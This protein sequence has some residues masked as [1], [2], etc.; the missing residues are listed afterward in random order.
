VHSSLKTFSTSLLSSVPRLV[1]RTEI[2]G[3]SCTTY[4][5][6]GPLEAFVDV[7][8]RESLSAILAVLSK[9]GLP[10]RVLGAGSNVLISSRGLSGLTL[11]LGRGFRYQIKDG[12]KKLRVGASTSL[13]SLSREV[14][15]QGLSG[16]EFAGGI[17]ASLGGAVV[18]NA[19]AHGGQLA[20]V[21]TSVQVV[22]PDGATEV[23]GA[24]DLELSYRHS[25]LPPGAVVTEVELSLAAGDP[26]K[27]AE[28]RQHFLAERKLRQ[29]L[30]S[31]SGGSVFRNPS[32][33]TSA[34][35]LIEQAGLKGREL[36]GARVSELH[37]NWIVNESRKATDEDV[38][39]LIA[40]CQAEV[41][42]RF[43]VELRPEL[44]VWG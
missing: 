30:Q 29:P 14:S 19:G 33:E 37:A 36:G 3:A 17:P 13:M 16:L 1:V 10:Y 35:S 18:M 38:R 6:G 20:D 24:E 5:I 12:E 15:E 44:V 41:R 11:R 2:T 9:E 42:S 28:R 31:P 4:A 22:L 23:L 27:I 43:G 21:L 8:D 34:G 25:K 39:G 40:L 7:P 32:P 26:Q